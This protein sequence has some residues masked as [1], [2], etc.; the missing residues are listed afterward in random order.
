MSELATRQQADTRRAGPARAA[1]SVPPRPR[2]RIASL[3]RAP[4]RVKVQVYLRLAVALVAIIFAL[5]PVVWI[6]SASLDPANSLVGQG[7]IPRNP[8]LVNYER[9]M[10]DPNNPF[11]RWLWN[12]VKVSG[13]TA[14]LSVVLT[15]MG[16][17][18][19]S[20][21][22]FRGRRPLFLSIL[23]VLVFPNMLAIVAVFLLIHQLGQFVPF[24][25]L[26]SHG[27][28]ILV[29]LG[30]VLGFNMF[31]I[32]GYFDSI[33]RD[34]DEAA[35]IDGASYAQIFLRVLFPLIRPIMAIVAVLVFIG[36]YSDFIMAKV[37][38]SSTDQFTLAVGLSLFIDGQFTQ[39]WGVFAAGALIGALPIVLIFVFLQ[40]YL[41]SGLVSGATKG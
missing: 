34:L 5:F 41:I 39:E 11:L 38:L 8:S 28:L 32:K 6:A 2:G 12:S 15:T 18:T 27:G 4:R 25:G 31:L 17:F 16:A 30:G 9:L 20:R 10:N 19:F 13:V 29:Y 14:A 21:F 36:T 22:R 40:N 23:L 33:P 7:L 3:R 35:L 37:L 1:T 24:F 26:N